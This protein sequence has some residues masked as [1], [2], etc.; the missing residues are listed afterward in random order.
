M[1]YASEFFVSLFPR[2]VKRRK[3]ALAALEN[4]QDALGALNDLTARMDI[5]PKEL[6][7]SAHARRVI[8]AQESNAGKLLQEAKAACAKL[9]EVKAFW[10]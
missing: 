9:G 6:H 7:Q 10:K 5:M 8:T 1:R 3:A 2:H 4:L